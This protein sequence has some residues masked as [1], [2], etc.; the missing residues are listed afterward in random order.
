MSIEKAGILT[1]IIGFLLLVAGVAAI[2][3]P[4]GLIVAGLLLLAWS[5]L[6]ARSLARNQQ[7]AG[8]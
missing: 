6:V 4:A 8:G 1:G 5:A 2:Y 3:W 7:K